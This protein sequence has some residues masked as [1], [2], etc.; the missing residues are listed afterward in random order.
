MQILGYL[1]SLGI[2]ELGSKKANFENSYIALLKDTG[3]MTVEDLAH[4]H[5]NV[6]L[7]KP[8]FW[9]MGLKTIDHDIETFLKLAKSEVS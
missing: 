1:F 6:D 3:Q 7:T 8:D 9:E 5:L 2:H 4:K